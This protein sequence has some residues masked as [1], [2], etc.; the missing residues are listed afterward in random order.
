MDP[1]C[2]VFLLGLRRLRRIFLCKE[3][4]RPRVLQEVTSE[5]FFCEDL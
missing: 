5:S 2:S 1:G 4:P 3:A